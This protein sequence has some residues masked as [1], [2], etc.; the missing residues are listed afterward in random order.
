M[1]GILFRTIVVVM[2]I[3]ATTAQASVAPDSIGIDSA[4]LKKEYQ[5][6]YKKLIVPAGLI[7]AGAAGI[8]VFTGFKCSLAS[9]FTNLR[10]N[11]YWHG[12]DYI[13]YVPAVAYLALGNCGVK[14]RNNLRDRV[15][16]GA[17]AYLCMAVIVNTTKFFVNE[18]RPES[19]AMNSF[20]SGHSA[21][22]F[23]GAELM[24]IEYGNAIGVAG[25]AVA[26]GVGFLRMYNGRH[27]YNDVLAG[28]GIG[29]LC[30]RLGYWLLPFEKRLFRL[31]TGN[32]AVLPFYSPHDKNI[33]IAVAAAF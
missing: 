29:I 4:A 26:A 28:A 12:D 32:T 15:M 14:S 9:D 17:T 30:A 13:Q 20:P 33:G 25:Y 5:F 10:K 1:F 24:R 6:N 11:N 2:L 22:V 8:R 3:T 7:A 21:T 31:R 27:W 16:A 19:G 18:R 23:L